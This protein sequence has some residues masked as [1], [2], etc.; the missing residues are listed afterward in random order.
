MELDALKNSWNTL[1]K[2]LAET[3][4]VNQRLVRQVV[5]GNTRTAITF[6]CQ[7]IDE[8]GYLVN[9]D[10]FEKNARYLRTALVA[11]NAYFSEGSD[12]SKKEYLYNI[13][14]DAFGL[15]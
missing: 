15:R 7:Y 4:I 9:R 5:E 2:R 13:V 14:E 8:M 10:L 12:F 1:D 11:F 3:E 6:C